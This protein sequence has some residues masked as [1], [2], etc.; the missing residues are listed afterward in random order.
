MDPP[1]SVR[2]FILQATYR[3]EGGRPVV[4]LYGRLETGETFLVRDRRAVPR[5][6]VL[7]RDRE[8]A[9]AAGVPRLAE[10]D[11]VTLAGEPVTSV[12]IPRPA[13]APP[14]RDRLHRAG[15]PTYEAD[16][17]FAVRYLID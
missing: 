12:E 16:V 13:N 15:I 1:A 17:R 4:H 2:G 14:L 5:F 9:R 3:I 7:A 11:L 8:A 10:S 6:Y